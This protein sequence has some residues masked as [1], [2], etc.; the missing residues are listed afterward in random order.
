MGPA[1]PRHVGSSQTRARTRVPCISRQIL[2]HCATRE[3]PR[4][5]LNLPV[6]IT[7]LV[8]AFSCDW[9][10]GIQGLSGSAAPWNVL[11][12]FCHVTGRNWGRAKSTDFPP[13]FLF[14]SPTFRDALYL[15]YLRLPA[16][17]WHGPQLSTP[18]CCLCCR[19]CIFSL[20]CLK[21]VSYHWTS[22]FLLL[23]C[24]DIF[25]FCHVPPL[26]LWVSTLKINYFIILLE[27][28]EG[29]D[30]SACLICHV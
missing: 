21:T 30:I 20:P 26:P 19:H 3:A 11:A 5:S 27:F 28:W 15:Q 2:N 23:K 13:T 6:F 4:F 10:S 24:L 16:F 22:L 9:H 17:P 1:A 25:I 8:L 18:A 12:T 14:S 29:T 7:A